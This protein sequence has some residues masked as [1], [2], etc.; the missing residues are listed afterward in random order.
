[1]ADDP[2]WI[3][4]LGTTQAADYMHEELTIDRDQFLHQSSLAA[5]AGTSHENNRSVL[6]RSCDEFRRK[7]LI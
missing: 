4:S 6:K 5:L 3:V 1:M 7:P 2:E